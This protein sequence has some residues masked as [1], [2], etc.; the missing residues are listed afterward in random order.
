MQDYNFLSIEKEETVQLKSFYKKVDDIS[1]KMDVIKNS[2]NPNGK[3]SSS[4][5]KIFSYDSKKR[6]NLFL[7]GKFF[8]TI[9]KKKKNLF[10][11]FLIKNQKT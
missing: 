1:E 2:N 11:S 5:W 3:S 7:I 6:K 10:L 8:L 4:D 9:L